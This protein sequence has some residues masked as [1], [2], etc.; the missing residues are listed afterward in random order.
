VIAYSPR[1]PAGSPRPCGLPIKVCRSA[2]SPAAATQ[3]NHPVVA[4]IR[5]I[6][7]AFLI[8]VLRAI[9]FKEDSVYVRQLQQ[10]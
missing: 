10:S 3:K 4:A 2:P 1:A 9:V 7:G 8:A 5:S 6:A